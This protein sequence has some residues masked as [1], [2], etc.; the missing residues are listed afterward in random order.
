M[1]VLGAEQLSPEIKGGSEV[2]NTFESTKR[3]LPLYP[4]SI[5]NQPIKP[6]SLEVAAEI[7]CI[8]PAGYEFRITWTS[9]RKHLQSR[10]YNNVLCHGLLSFVI[11]TLLPL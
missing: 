3:E 8:R 7:M 2:Y 5:S 10:L 11:I 6:L 1:N 9:L 4:N